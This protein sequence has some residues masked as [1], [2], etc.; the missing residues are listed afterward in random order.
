MGI[1]QKTMVYLARLYCVIRS[2]HKGFWRSLK[3]GT[4]QIAVSGCRVDY[5]AVNGERINLLPTSWVLESTGFQPMWKVGQGR[6]FR[7]SLALSPKP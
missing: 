7:E 1:V 3:S 6:G 5:L 4:C 2:W